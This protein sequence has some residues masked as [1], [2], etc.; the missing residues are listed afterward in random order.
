[1]SAGR[2][3]SSRSHFEEALAIYDPISHRSLPFHPQVVVP[4][5][6]GLAVFCLGFPDQAL[7]QSNAAIVKARRLAHPTA[8][9]VSLSNGTRL[10]SLFAEPAGLDDLADQLV[11][12]AT[13]QGFPFW[14]A[15]GTIYSGWAKA[16]RQKSKWAIRRRGWLFCG[17][18]R[19][20]TAPLERNSGCPIILPSWPAHVRS[21]VKLKMDLNWTC[22]RFVGFIADRRR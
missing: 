1:M 2:F 3:A 18:V 12:L 7:A 20:L 17:A 11:A 21:R 6:L 16:G 9:A 15:Q 4:G 22:R 5:F 8:L 10:L 14:R 13:E 19:R